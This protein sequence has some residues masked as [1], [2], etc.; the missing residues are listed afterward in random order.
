MKRLIL[1]FSA[2]AAL[3]CAPRVQR[4]QDGSYR[5]E[6]ES[7][8][9]ECVRKVERHCRG[10]GYQI[11]DGTED[12]KLVGIE[13]Q[14]AGYLRSRV[15]FHC[16]DR[17]PPKP[18]KLPP[19]AS[20]PPEP[21]LTASESVSRP[22][23]RVCIPGATQRCVGPGACGGGQACLKDGS[24][25]G[26]CECVPKGASSTDTDWGK[27]VQSPSGSPSAGTDEATAR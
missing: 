27:A 3:A 14:Q 8:L 22:P 20:A 17:I 4:L 13:G 10:E 25:Y 21:A 19:R 15:T 23:A 12:N 24:G 26:P 2:V 1:L 7:T 11:V 5:M 9:A 6:C 18:L 16:A